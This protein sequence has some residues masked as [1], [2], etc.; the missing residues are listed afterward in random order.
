[1]INDV[2]RWNVCMYK[3]EKTAENGL[4]E[5]LL[6]LGGHG[7]LVDDLGDLK[8]ENH[9]LYRG[10]IPIIDDKYCLLAG[11]S[12][13]FIKIENDEIYTYYHFILENDGNKDVRYGVYANGLLTETPSEVQFTNHTYEE[14]M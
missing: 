11:I 13:D 6:V 10:K 12:K 14:Y 7:I 8:E 2:R 9:R 5:D 1:M 3:M 4:L